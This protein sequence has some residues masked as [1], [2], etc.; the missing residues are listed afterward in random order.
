MRK[1]KQGSL[2]SFGKEVTTSNPQAALTQVLFFFWRQRVGGKLGSRFWEC[3]FFFFSP[4][5]DLMLLS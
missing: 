4:V 1:R 2:S 3:L 5:K